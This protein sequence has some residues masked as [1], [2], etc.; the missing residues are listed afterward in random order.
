MIATLLAVAL[1]APP[2]AGP[3]PAPAPGSITGV[4]Q[5]SG[6]PAPIA[7]ARVTLPDGTFRITGL[8][9]G[10]YRLTPAPP[11]PSLP[12]PNQLEIMTSAIMGTRSTVNV[13][14]RNADVSGVTVV[15]RPP[16]Q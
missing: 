5:E 16:Q 14:V 15:L 10:T 7:D 1:V 6:S 2:Q 3:A 8:G 9:P 12:P 13:V 4:V 11:P